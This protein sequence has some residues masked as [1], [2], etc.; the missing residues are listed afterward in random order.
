MQTLKVVL[1]SITHTILYASP[2][3]NRLI[4]PVELLSLGRLAYAHSSLL[5]DGLF[6]VSDDLSFPPSQ[7]D[8]FSL[9]SWFDRSRALICFFL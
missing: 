2:V 1:A 8:I 4:E 9:I 6:H 7:V 3:Y 5:S